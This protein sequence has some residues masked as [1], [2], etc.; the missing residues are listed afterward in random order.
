MNGPTYEL[1]PVL[2]CHAREAFS[3]VY[4]S[5]VS[6]AIL[7][8]HSREKFTNFLCSVTSG[9]KVLAMNRKLCYTRKYHIRFKKWLFLTGID[10]KPEDRR[11]RSKSWDFQTGGDIFPVQSHF[12]LKNRLF[13][14]GNDVKTYFKLFCMTSLPVWKSQDW[15]GS[16][17]TREN[18]PSGLENGFSQ[19]ES[20]SNRKIVASSR[21][22]EIFEPAATFFEYNLTFD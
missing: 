17:V 5:S 8:I 7:K 20:T 21:R 15:T 12:R 14:T 11:Y 22:V 9:L 18:I 2:D 4:N 10:V 3:S 1:P 13:Q 6:V 19:P 16:Y